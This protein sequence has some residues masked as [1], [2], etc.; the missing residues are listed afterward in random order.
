MREGIPPVISLTPNP[1]I[2]AGTEPDRTLLVC[3][4][5]A[6]YEIRYVEQE[7]KYR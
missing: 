7:L 1:K 4:F 5:G 6:S 3:F 2:L